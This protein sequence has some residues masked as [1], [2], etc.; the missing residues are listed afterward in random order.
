MRQARIILEGSEVDAVIEGEDA[1]AR[2]G[3]RVSL[4]AVRFAPPCLPT[5]VVCVGLNYR[6]HAAEMGVEIPKDALLFL[7]PPSAVIAHDAPIPYPSHT[8]RLEY[9]AELAVVIGR[10]ARTVPRARALEHVWGYTAFND[11]TARDAQKVESQWVRAKAFDA[12]APLGPWIVTDFD[13][14]GR[15]VIARVNGQERQHG[16]TRDLIFDIPTIIEIISA[17][18]TL[19]RGDVIATGTPKG[20]GPVIPGDVVE[21]EIG[22]IGVLRN[23]IAARA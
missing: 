18:M 19:E 4:E 2:D 21:I 5:K 9:E 10:T 3:R 14:A 22:G 12:S 8:Q 13:P 1:I 17:I 6:D 23:R 7:K 11:L 16:N 20:V 15:D